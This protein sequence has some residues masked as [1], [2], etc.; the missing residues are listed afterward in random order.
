MYNYDGEMSTNSIMYQKWGCGIHC[1]FSGRWAEGK[2]DEGTHV[3]PQYQSSD[4]CRRRVRAGEKGR[5]G[6]GE[7]QCE[8][9]EGSTGKEEREWDA[10]GRREVRK[11]GDEEGKMRIQYMKSHTMSRVEISRLF[12]KLAKLRL[13]A[14]TSLYS[15]FPK[16][17]CILCTLICTCKL[18]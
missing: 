16:H 17:T 15:H 6:E 1:G 11:W 10:E 9:K 7:K 18:L 8:G 3:A 13:L 4:H 2:W 12:V 5:M 14:K